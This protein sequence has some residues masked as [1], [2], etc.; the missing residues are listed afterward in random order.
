MHKGVIMLLAIGRV[1]ISFSNGVLNVGVPVGKVRVGL[2]LNRN[3]LT[4]DVFARLTA[5][6]K[7]MYEGIV[8]K[9]NDA[10]TS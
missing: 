3:V 8:V 1:E 7:I 5:E 4:G 10:K 2:L 9:N 6:H